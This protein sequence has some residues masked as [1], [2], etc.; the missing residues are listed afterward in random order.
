MT[1]TAPPA[2]TE[3]RALADAQRWQ[4]L[5]DLLRDVDPASVGAS[6][7][8]VA[9][10]KAHAALADEAATERWLDRSLVLLPDNATLWRNKGAAHQKRGHWADARE[11][12]E[13]AAQLRPDI[14]SYRGS[15]ALCH[16]QLGDY[17]AAVDAFRTALAL[18]DS[19]RGW[20]IRL[21]RAL[22]LTGAP[23]EAAT[24]YARALALQADPA[25]Q[26]AHDELLRQIEIGSR[27]ASAGYYDA[28][29]ADSRKYAQHGDSSDYAPVWDRI[30]RALED[31]GGPAV[32]VLDLGCGPGQFAEF[33]A[34]RLPG[35]AYCGIDFSGVAIAQARQR[36][37]AF[38][39]EQRELPLG[40]FVDLPPFDVVVCTEVLE[41]VEADREILAALPPGTPVLAT[42]PN[43]DSFG[44]L[45]VFRDEASVRERYA[46][47]FED[48]LSI[49]GHAMSATATLWLMRGVRRAAGDDRHA[50]TAPQAS[51]AAAPLPPGHVDLLASVVES[52]FLADGTRYVEDFLPLFG[53]PFVAVADAVELAAA[54]RPHVALRHDVDWSIDNALAMATLEHQ[55]GVRSSYYLLHPD[56]DITR[57]NYFGRIDDD[58]RLVLD[59]RLFE[60]ARRLAD[61]GHEVGLHNDLISLSLATGRAP[62]E[63]LEQICEA[64]AARGLPL[65]GSVSHGSR[66]CRTHGY[67]NHQVFAELRDAPMAVDY[68]N[69]PELFELYARPVV[70]AQ[71]PHERRRVDKFT[72]R[73]SDFGL[74][75]E[76]NFVPRAVYLYDSASRWTIWDGEDRTEF[77]KHEPAAHWRDALEAALVRHG[78]ATT[79]QALVHPCHWAPLAQFNAQSIAG[80]RSRRDAGADTARRGMRATRLAALPNVLC[81]QPSQRFDGYDRKYA[82]KHQLYTIAPTV[83]Q[84]VDQLAAGPAR[85]AR[86]LL[87]TGCGQGDFLERVRHAIA[88]AAGPDAADA[89]PR[90]AL[91]VDGSAA[92]ILDCATR[93]PQASWACAPLEDFVSRHDEHFAARGQTAPRYDLVLDKTGAIFIEDHDAARAYFAALAGLMAP[94]GLYVYVASRNYYRESLC[95]N[96]YASWPADWLALADA[97]FEPVSSHDDQLPELRGYIKRIWRRR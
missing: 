46:P 5:A 50:G 3:I 19:Q 92:G 59:A 29:Y 81:A 76:A 13:R 49:E 33:L 21:A 84:F 61:L 71:T 82:A 40:A 79:V 53:G 97:Q 18:D 15:A 70:E 54:G 85:S 2:D 20:W 62:G 24:A 48:G 89:P 64:F 58:G 41:H 83:N 88:A 43:F 14:A 68:R 44:H 75:Y 66:T 57:E 87:E 22:I 16:H 60:H 47:F 72:L 90:F 27:A 74:R 42:V 37:P 52:I 63:Y 96:V 8:A 39:F 7:S 9:A 45:R 55:Q 73:M 25:T 94:G 80:A 30:V 86:T 38:R 6:G 78:A 51:P 32:R 31:V 77:A 12:F 65:A 56:G 10:W 91:G 67:M 35:A 1:A 11:C 36:V 34:G 28:V 95:R 26:S 4:D 23:Q 17:P 93:Y 69:K